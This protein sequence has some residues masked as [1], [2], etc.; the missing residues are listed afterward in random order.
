VIVLLITLV[1]DVTNVKPEN[2]ETCAINNVLQDVKVAC[3]K[4]IPEI[5][6]T[7]VL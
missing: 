5:A 3:V 7:D 1:L 4:R 2:M 6:Q